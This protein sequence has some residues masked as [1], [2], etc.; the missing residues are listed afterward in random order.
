MRGIERYRQHANQL[1]DFWGR[2]RNAPRHRLEAEFFGRTLEIVSNDE[3]PLRAVERV[4]PLYSVAA[5]GDSA[6][7][8]VQIAVDAGSGI[9]VP[10]DL[11]QRVRYAGHGDWAL[12]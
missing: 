3:R 7:G 9:P 12:V 11:A 1:E 2:R 8:R 5:M 4:Q 6:S 10:D